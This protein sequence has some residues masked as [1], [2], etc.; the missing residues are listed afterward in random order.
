MAWKVGSSVT[1]E[2]FILFYIV[3]HVDKAAIVATII[4]SLVISAREAFRNP[5]I[6]EDMAGNKPRHVVIC[7]LLALHVRVGYT[8]FMN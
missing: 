1:A 5:V 7:T 8:P 4:F 3:S 6:A 2:Q